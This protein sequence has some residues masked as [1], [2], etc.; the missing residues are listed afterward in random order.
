MRFV[1]SA[2]FEKHL[3]IL[4]NRNFALLLCGQ[5]ISQIGDFVF[6]T[7]L[8]LWVGTIIA[9][10]QPWAPTAV[11]V[12][13][14][15]TAL[16]A[17][18]FG[19]VAGVFVD[20]LDK[21]QTMFVADVLR[22]ILIGLLILVMGFVPIPPFLSQRHLPV[23]WQLGTIYIVVFLTSLCAQFFNP[24]HLTL[25]GDIVDEPYRA[26]ASGLEQMT[27]NVA[28]IVGPLLA[29][30]L[31]FAVGI[32]WALCIDALSFVVSFLAI[33]FICPPAE[34]ELPSDAGLHNFLHQFR[35]GLHF[36]AGHHILRTLALTMFLVLFSGGI[37]ANLNLFFVTQNLHATPQLY[38]VLNAASG[39]GLLM[40]AILVSWCMQHLG[41]ARSFWGS[42]IAIGVL[43]VVYARL[44]NFPVACCILLL[45]G[46][47]NAALNVAWGP[48]LLR[49]T[50][51]AFMGRISA[52]LSPILQSAMLLS[53]SIV[54]YLMST[55]L[56]TFHVTILG[57]TLGP[58]DT[59]IMIAGLV[60]L[61]GGLYAMSQLRT[62]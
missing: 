21:R 42:I 2:V 6:N 61:A 58:L 36:F 18:L 20:R 12:L 59:M 1:P 33:F 5:A 50:P 15:V 17:L 30:P 25:L 31:V 44:T 14:F 34:K 9:D 8:V 52:L 47:C 54:G 48:L 11:S 24:A 13:L 29:V 46:M 7:T 51:R 56:Y 62:V 38:G 22:A 53:T 55:V 41:L 37:S 35:T 49:I 40:G 43:E 23:F 16:P 19:P 28:M 4:I 26:Q 10:G 3:H 45:Q 60:A 27:W 57:I 32:P 39:V